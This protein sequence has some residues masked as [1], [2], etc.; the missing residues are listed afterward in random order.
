VDPEGP[1]GDYQS[2]SGSVAYRF[3]NPTALRA[4]LEVINIAMFGK[5]DNVQTGYQSPTPRGKVP[6]PPPQKKI[7]IIK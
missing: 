7:I 6:L 1:P 5:K 3:Q 2:I 4:V